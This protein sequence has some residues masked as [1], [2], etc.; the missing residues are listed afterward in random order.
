MKA[1][2]IIPLLICYVVSGQSK[3]SIA[4]AQLII[5]DYKTFN[6]WD[7]KKHVQH[8]QPHYILIENGDI[9]SL[10]DEV[11]YFRKNAHRSIKRT[12]QFNFFS[13]RVQRNF[14]YAIYELESTIEEDGKSKFYK[15]TESAIC[16]KAARGW[17]LALIHSTVV[18]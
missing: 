18:K 12:D 16:E 15:W 13:I 3:D 14:G 7:Y 2:L 11:N 9:M 17:K 8:Y 1:I 4:I 10:Q 5:N 6:S